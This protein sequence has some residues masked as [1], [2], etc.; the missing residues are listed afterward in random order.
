METEEKK[1]AKE[2]PTN[3][4]EENGRGRLIKV[5]MQMFAERGFDS[6]TVRELSAQA[7]VS[8][9]LI[10]HHFGSKEGLRDEVDAYF[11]KQTSAALEQ[12]LSA[13]AGQSSEYV[14]EYERSWINK[15]SEEFPGFVA[16]FRRAIMEKNAW[17][18]SFFKRYYNSFRLVT[19]RLDVT[20]QIDPKV[21]KIWLPWLYCFI[22]LGPAVFDP[23]IESVLGV[24]SYEPEMF[25]RFHRAAHTFLWNGIGAQSKNND[26]KSDNDTTNPVPP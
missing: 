2:K 26:S 11:L 22:Y 25:A 18:E 4:R 13:I 5:A 9:G 6:V 14:G 3:V 20:G 19:D 21:D 8:V 16:Y 12:T 10:K 24:S 7:N 23:F 15:Y 17:S 1:V